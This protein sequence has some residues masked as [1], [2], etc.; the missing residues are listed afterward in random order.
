MKQVYVIRKEETQP[1]P[2]F[3]GYN[4]LERF[5][6]NP[7]NPKEKSLGKDGLRV[8]TKLNNGRV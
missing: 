4:P 5:F 2:L 3:T 1:K 8:N 7:K 6:V